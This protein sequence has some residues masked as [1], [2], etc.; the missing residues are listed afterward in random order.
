M[1]GSVATILDGANTGGDR[2][3]SMAWRTR[4]TAEAAP[5]KL[6]SDVVDLTGMVNSAPHETDPFVLE[7][8]FNPSLLMN[9]GQYSAL[10]AQ[11]SIYL[12]YLNGGGI[13]ANA[14][15]GN[16]GGSSFFAGVGAYNSGT[17]FNLGYWGVD[18]STNTA[19]AVV[20]HNGQ[21]AVVP[22]PATLVL[23]AI[24]LLGLLA[25]GWRKRK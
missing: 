7:M 20:N 25:Y 18:T 23:A 16:I 11:G 9:P 10:A 6:I 4:T 13:W 8:S 21:F 14:V 12:A 3:I 24:G 2:S 5:G 19:W 22:E 17:D 1:V 15:D